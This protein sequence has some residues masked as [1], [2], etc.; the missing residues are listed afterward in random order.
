M[1]I[2]IA[3]VAAALFYASP[4][5]AGIKFHGNFLWALAASV[6]FN[7]AFWGLECLLAVVVVGINIGTLGLGAIITSSLKF[8]AALIAPSVALFGTAT[9]LPGCLRITGIFPGAIV[10]GLM[11]G[12]LLWASV[13]QKGKS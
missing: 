3:L 6:V 8:L 7:V 12:G 11:L 9:I 2:R 4:Y 1:S 13:P 10:Y 5:V